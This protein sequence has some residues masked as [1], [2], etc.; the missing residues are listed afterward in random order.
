MPFAYYGAKHGLA[1]KYPRPRHPVVVEPFA[2][3]AAYSVHHAATID[4]AILID[5]DHRVVEL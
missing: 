2:G 1:S 4:H 5:A 3:S